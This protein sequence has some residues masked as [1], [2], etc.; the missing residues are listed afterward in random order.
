MAS[1]KGS[2][3]EKDVERFFTLLGY[4]TKTNVRIKGYEIDVLAIHGKTNIIVECKQRDQ[5]ESLDLRN[6]IHQWASKNQIIQANKV[7][8]ITHG[9]DIL[10]SHKAL[11]KKL[12]VSVWSDKDFNNYLDTALKDKKKALRMLDEYLKLDKISGKELDVQE[13]SEF[14]DRRKVKVEN[15]VERI[16]KSG[17]FGE[18][19]LLIESDA[20]S[21]EF[22]L[23]P[24]GFAMFLHPDYK[25]YG[26]NEF[27]PLIEADG[28]W[29]T[30]E[31]YYELSGSVEESYEIV[32]KSFLEKERRI[33]KFT[34]Q[35]GDSDNFIIV[36]IRGRFQKKEGMFFKKIVEKTM[37]AGYVIIVKEDDI[38]DYVEKVNKYFGSDEHYDITIKIGK[39]AI[40]LPRE[41]YKPII[42]KH[43]NV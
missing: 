29:G 12:G 23:I 13:F 43:W 7:M 35:F 28:D 40:P 5:S 31:D 26:K 21:L 25:W 6:L 1:R 27:G 38:F 4:R 34:E 9:L 39:S 2:L 42:K 20:V 8:I 30:N 22:Y 19:T 37:I 11:G 16:L 36:T 17:F 41:F 3:L 14:Q 33:I 10:Y 24:K 15:V 32:P 18:S